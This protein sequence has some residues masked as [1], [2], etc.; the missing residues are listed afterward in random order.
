MTSQT[1][2]TTKKAL[3]AELDRL[4]SEYLGFK[5]TAYGWHSKPK[6]QIEAQIMRMR[7]AILYRRL[8]KDYAPT[9]HDGL[10]QALSGNFTASMAFYMWLKDVSQHLYHGDDELAAI[11]RADSRSIREMAL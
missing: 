9:S 2:T 8:A 4:Y 10:A 7:R 11:A 5:S 6:V 3:V 1:S